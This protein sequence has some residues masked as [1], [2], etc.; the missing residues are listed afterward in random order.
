MRD[1]RMSANDPDGEHGV[2]VTIPQHGTREQYSKDTAILRKR[3][4]IF[5][6]S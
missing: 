2:G 1:A 5:W 4:I 3:K 6:A